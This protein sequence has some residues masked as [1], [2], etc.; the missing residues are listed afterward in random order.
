MTCGSRTADRRIW[1]AYLHGIFDRNNF[2][3]WFI[4]LLRGQ[5]NL[6]P[7]GKEGANYNVDKSL[8][9]LAELVRSSIDVEKIYQLMNL[10]P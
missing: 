8:D 10:E 4:D 1:G 5:K 2:R 7:K 3:R 6:A 9:E